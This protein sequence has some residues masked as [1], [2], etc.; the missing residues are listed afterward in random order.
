MITP[1]LKLALEPI[2]SRHRLV[3]T[4]VWSAVLLGALA[5]GLWVWKATGHRAPIP[6][7]AVLTYLLGLRVPKVIGNRWEPD[8]TAIARQIEQ[9][10]PELHVLLLT[11]IEQRPDPETGKLHFLQQRVIADV[12]CLARA[13]PWIDVA[14]KWKVA[15]G[16][17]VVALATCALFFASKPAPKAEKKRTVAAVEAPKTDGVE[18]TPGDTEVERG[19]GLVVLAKFGRNVPSEAALVVQPLNAPAQRIPLVKNLDDPVFG[20]G[21]PEVNADLTYRIEYAGEATRDFT[22][23][24][25]EH[26]RLDRADAT[27]HFP[28]YTA[29]PDKTVPDTRRVS[30]VEGTKLDVT[31]NLNKPVKSAQ[32]VTKAEQVVPLVVDPAKPIATLSGFTIAASQSYELRLVDADGRANKVPAQFIIDALPNRKPELKLVTPRGDV[33]VSPLEEVAFRTEVW[34][35]FGLTRHGIT[36]TVAG[37]EPK[38]VPLGTAT[39]ADERVA[40]EHVLKLESLGMKPD[41]LV[42]Y[43]AWAEDTG[44][45]GKPRRTATD[46]FFAEVR[47]F[48][49]IYRPGDGSEGKQQEKGA[50]GDATKLAELQKQIITATWNLK[51]GEDAN[52]GD[53]KPT[54]KYLEDEPVVRDSQAEALK[55]AQALAE[56]AEEPKSQ[57][58]AENVMHEMQG[59]LDQL[60][61]S[62]KTAEPLPK[63]L[64]AEQAAYNALLKLA[65]HEFRIT[66]NQRS[67]GEKSGKQ[68][69]MQAQLDELEMKDEKK[70]YEQKSEAEEQQNEQQKEQLAILNRLKEL[71]QRQQ[72]INERLKELQ[73]ALQAA[74][75]DKEKEEIQRQLKRLREEEQQ[76][77][78]D[79]DEAKQK[80]EQSPQQSQ[81][82]EERKQL[83][84]TRNEAQ[85][86]AEAMERNQASQALANGTRAQRQLDQLRDEFRKKTSG[87]FNDEMR[88]MRRE[89]RELAENQKE[90]ADK[91]AAEPDKPQ[92]RTLDGSS[93][94]EQLAKKF[95]E[96]QEKLG[97]VTE[98]MKRV[99]EQAEV[100]EPLLAKELY[101]TLRKTAQADTAKTL[102]MTKALNQR[103]YG[104]Q[105]RKFEEKAR[106]EI[107]EIKT[108]VERAAESVLGDE[109]EALRQARAELDTLTKQLNR[110]IAQNRPDLAEGK[111]STEAKPGEPQAKAGDGKQSGEPSGKDGKSGEKPQPGEGESQSKQPGQLAQKSEAKQPGEGQQPDGKQPGQ[112]KPGEG[113]QAN[114]QPQGQGQPNTPG[115]QP[116]KE[117]QP[118]QAQQPGQIAQGRGEQGGQPGQPGEG[119]G[120]ETSREGKPGDTQQSPSRLGEIAKG[121]Q[122]G[123]TNDRGGMWGGATDGEQAGP[124]TGEKFVEWSDRLRKV[125]EMID[126]PALRTEA[127]RVRE[128]AKGVRAEFKRHSVAPNWEMVNT[129]IREPLAELRNRLTEELA[130]RDSKENLVPI[131]RDPVPAQYAE[132]VR[133]Y[134]EELGRSR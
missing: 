18:V 105:A 10:H 61:A 21:L 29:Q 118:G 45:D 13:H 107:E 122:R 6:V 104:E 92:R 54:A 49:E 42:S 47:P 46:M 71:A 2:V 14:P 35:D 106:A 112:G 39:K 98:D 94:R 8:F 102:E 64:A 20:G 95:D 85:Q 89:A 114:A 69:Q 119:A 72:D 5:L 81:L 115:Q 3:R 73:T 48:E 31:F 44:P 84:Q 24:V 67:K 93:E 68:Q 131:D 59:A 22:V 87:Q 117:Q 86:A 110:E 113:Q 63:A 74:K 53:Q 41:E 27:L 26:P 77:L 57:E 99:S 12:L 108:G 129:K 66:R 16:Y 76:L 103:G 50:G 123:G 80:M 79:I 32:L 55:Q 9:K 90:I 11:A 127:A 34:D 121:R 15:G 19:T 60:K 43:F 120:R 75:T 91:L 134:Y 126:D 128:V 33:R 78:S 124:L 83:E 23:K 111:E 101:D 30:A 96:Q 88:E 116:G 56:K 65:A 51:R 62:E 17:A 100:A 40:S 25:F 133:R 28:T 130:R 52:L 4:L 37:Q 132:R 125:E 36:Y 1:L 38:D 82:A 109:A 58:I 97:G 7:L 70:R